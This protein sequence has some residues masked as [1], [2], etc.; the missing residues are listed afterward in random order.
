MDRNTREFIRYGSRRMKWYWRSNGNNE[1]W[2]ADVESSG[3][4]L[5]SYSA[6]VGIWNIPFPQNE[7]NN[8]ILW[9][10]DLWPALKRNSLFTGPKFSRLTADKETDAES[11]E[12]GKLD[13]SAFASNN[14]P[15]IL[16]P[17][18]GPT[19]MPA[20]TSLWSLDERNGVRA[21]HHWIFMRAKY[22]L[23]FVDLFWR[24]IGGGE[25]WM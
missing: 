19:L 2:P 25:R 9:R 11:R 7:R 24:E 18:W 14:L 12:K 1:L 16:S 10:C 8:V 17:K 5:A 6:K 20:P 4:A 3:N 13:G 21:A 23:I 15:I 22:S